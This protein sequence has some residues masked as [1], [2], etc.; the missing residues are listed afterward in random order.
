[1]WSK[2]SGYVPY[3][4]SLSRAEQ[5]TISQSQGETVSVEDL[6]AKNLIGEH[7][8]LLS[9]T[10]F[11]S[12]SSE[13]G[14]ILN[15]WF[16]SDHNAINIQPRE[17][18]NAEDLKLRQTEKIGFQVDF[19]GNIRSIHVN[20]E[21]VSQVP[22]RYADR[23]DA[24][25]QYIANVTRCDAKIV[26]VVENNPSV[27]NNNNNQIVQD[28]KTHSVSELPSCSF[29]QGMLLEAAEVASP[30]L[31]SRM[32]YAINNISTSLATWKISK[33]ALGELCPDFSYSGVSAFIVLGMW[34][35]F[36]PKEA[37]EDLLHG[38]GLDGISTEDFLSGVQHIVTELV[39]RSDSENAAILELQQA[40]GK[41]SSDV[42]Y[43]NPEI[44]KLFERL[45]HL[46]ITADAPELAKKLTKKIKKL[47]H[48]LI[49]I[50]VAPLTRLALLN[51]IYLDAKWEY[52]FE[53][54]RRCGGESN[55][56]P[57]SGEKIKVSRMR[58]EVRHGE[59]KFHLSY[60]DKVNKKPK[61]APIRYY[62]TPEG[63]AT[64]GFKMIQLPYKGT[65]MEQLIFLPDQ[66]VNF[67]QFQKI[68]NSDEID[69][70]A[71]KARSLEQEQELTIG[72]PSATIK[73][74]HKDLPEAFKDI[75]SVNVAQVDSSATHMLDGTPLVVTLQQNTYF[76][77]NLK[78]SKAAAVTIMQMMDGGFGFSKKKYLSFIANRPHIMVIRRKGVILFY[79]CV[80]KGDSLKTDKWK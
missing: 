5:T 58:K 31:I 27:S 77:N 19:N 78:G 42:L 59:E 67:R 53:A 16:N 62:E 18:Y 26:S 76:E 30:Q 43:L 10:K 66:D 34:L 22:I 40:F 9:N 21:A 70:F 12:F 39:E 72:L 41:S 8:H 23:L 64:G 29:V 55:Y 37:R 57:P 46:E 79:S 14:E 35:P 24:F 44:T 25:S 28:Q 54:K 61:P 60:W 17:I 7:R 49:D 38:L 56:C 51:S 11:I 80:E 45:S 50:Q 65:D 4:S 3:L 47:T 63:W 74:E 13:S 20:N 15:V 75:F 6:K 33:I 1:M 52:P 36:A 73:S 2:L 71:S 48:D 69:S 32:K 68:L